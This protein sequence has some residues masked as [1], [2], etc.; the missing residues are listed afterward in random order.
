[1]LARIPVLSDRDESNEPGVAFNLAVFLSYFR[2]GPYKVIFGMIDRR[3][4]N[5]IDPKWKSA[6]IWVCLPSSSD[7]QLGDCYVMGHP[8]NRALE[9]MDKH[10]TSFF[11]V[12]RA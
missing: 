7:S 3:E 4:K 11:E 10:R 9:R 12:S 6:S 5:V 8:D 2:R 1:M